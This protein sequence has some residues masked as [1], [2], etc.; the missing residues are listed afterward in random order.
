[1]MQVRKA[2][3]EKIARSVFVQVGLEVEALWASLFADEVQVVGF[4]VGVHSQR[5]VGGYL[6]EQTQIVVFGGLFRV[7]GGEWDGQAVIEE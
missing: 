2:I 6:E 1:M 7:V 4:G 3:F 5:G